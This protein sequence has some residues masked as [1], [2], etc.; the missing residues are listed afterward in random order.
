M[1]MGPLARRFGV[2]PSAIVIVHDELDLSVADL[3]L[4]LGG[5]R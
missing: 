4:K 1:A 2:E 5:G 3:K